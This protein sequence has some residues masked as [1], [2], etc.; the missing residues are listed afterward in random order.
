[1]G[2]PASHLIVSDHPADP[3]L[4]LQREDVIGHIPGAAEHVAF[5]LHV[6]DGHRGLGGYPLHLPPDVVI[7]DQIPNH[8]HRSLM[9][10]L[11]I[12]DKTLHLHLMPD[13]SGNYTCYLINIPILSHLT[14]LSSPFHDQYMMNALPLILFSL[15]N[16]Q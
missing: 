6:N 11:D 10:I 3:D 7:G 8:G 5:P 15:T 2:N 1:M 9:K 4:T 14:H 16:P 13:H 12:T